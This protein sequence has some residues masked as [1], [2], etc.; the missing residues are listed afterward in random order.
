MINIYKPFYSIH[1]ILVICIILLFLLSACTGRTSNHGIL[2]IDNHIQNIVQNNME[3]AEVEIILGPPSIVSTFD[4]N[5]WYY[6]S[7]KIHRVGVLK[8]KVLEHQIYEIIFDEENHVIDVQQYDLSNF[9]E[10]DYNDKE[11]ATKGN[12]KNLIELLIRS[13]SKLPN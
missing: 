2:N 10:I 7:N 3:K 9:K 1:Q 8:P 5:K 6:M 12:E 4:D 11:T 13:S